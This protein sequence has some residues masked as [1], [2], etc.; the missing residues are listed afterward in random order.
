[1]LVTRIIKDINHRAIELIADVFENR[2]N[3]ILNNI[4]KKVMNFPKKFMREISR[5]HVLAIV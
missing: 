2:L 5:W 1:M 3:I 4:K